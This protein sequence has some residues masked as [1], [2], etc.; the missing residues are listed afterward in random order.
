MEW[1]EVNPIPSACQ[2]CEELDC[3]NCDVVG[4]RW[5]LPRED[6]LRLRRQSLVKAIERFQKRL[7]I[8]DME[9]LP[10]TKQQRDVLTGMEDMSY[11]I[12]WQCLELCF[13]NDNM[14]MYMRIWK[15][16]P[17]HV[18]QVMQLKNK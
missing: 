16:H 3:Y 7:E 17:E 5:L 8:I 6:E 9:L 10:F 15:K 2:Y 12:F 1:I 14:D 11:E 18:S 13:Q 4:E